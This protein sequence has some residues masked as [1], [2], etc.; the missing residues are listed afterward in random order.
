METYFSKTC[1]W[2]AL[3]FSGVVWGLAGLK[4]PAEISRASRIKL[5]ILPIAIGFFTFHILF[6]FKIGGWFSLG[7]YNL[8]FLS[9][10][11]I[12]IVMGSQSRDLK[13]TISGCI[14]FAIIVISRYTDLFHS[15][16]ARA[17]VFFIIGA[18]IFMAANLYSRS[19]KQINKDMP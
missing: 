17:I 8:I 19:K 6:P 12:F 14:F 2:A 11:I 15:L 10:A 5:W 4:K 3:I 16:I 9:H 1:F 7:I 18:G 13:Q